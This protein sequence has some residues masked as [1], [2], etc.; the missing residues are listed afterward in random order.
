MTLDFK[1]PKE[2]NLGQWLEVA[3]SGLV[4]PAKERIQME[5]EAHYAEAVANHMAH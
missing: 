2:K 1:V 3:T 5:I 4:A